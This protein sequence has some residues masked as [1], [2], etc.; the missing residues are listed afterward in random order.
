M[1]RVVIGEIGEEVSRFCKSKFKYIN[2]E[3]WM[4]NIYNLHNSED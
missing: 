2:T 4:Y 3:I 1:Q